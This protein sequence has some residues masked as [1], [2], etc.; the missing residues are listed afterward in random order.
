M[1]ILTKK[2]NKQFSLKNA[3]AHSKPKNVKPK[4]AI[5]TLTN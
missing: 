1:I 3:S 2:R 4:Y 5:A